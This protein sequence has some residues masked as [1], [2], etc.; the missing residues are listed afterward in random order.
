MSATKLTER[1]PEARFA[2]RV[3]DF[4]ARR[5]AVAYLG[6][7]YIAFLLFGRSADVPDLT[8]LTVF[9]GATIVAFGAGYSIQVAY[10]PHIVPV[11]PSE[12]VPLALIV[13]CATYFLALGASYL[14]L[15]G[16][17][18]PAAILQA[19]ANPGASYFD[20][21]HSE[22]APNSS[23][24]RA[25]T[26]TACLYPLLIPL[27][28]FHWNRLKWTV[29]ALIIAGITAYAAYYISIG[30]L[31][32]LGDLVVFWVV[33]YSAKRIA[34]RMQTT[35][36]R[37]KPLT[38]SQKASIAVVVSIF[39]G[40]MAFNQMTR[41][42]EAGQADMFPP[43]PVVAA[44]VGTDLATGLSASMF[45]PVHGY[46]GLGY[47]LETPFRW[48]YGLGGSPALGG[49]WQQ[50]TGGDSQAHNRYTART[51]SLSDWPDGMYW[52]TIYPWL[53]SDLTFPGTVLFMAVVGWFLSKFWRE[54][55]HQRRILS[56]SMLC[57][58]SLAIAFVPANNQIG[59]GRASLIAFVTTAAL[60]VA[61]RVRSAVKEARKSHR[62]K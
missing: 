58:I 38:K 3:V 13:T 14:Y 59:Q 46:L 37:A 34:D 28:V 1:P 43:N 39:L 61:D 60:S 2:A 22:Q 47:N 15:T 35:V 45:Y 21:L 52:S 53:A 49:Y 31:K 26:L 27:A 23:A 17:S 6:S 24:I 20:R 30:T 62:A 42:E 44:I 51:E 16:V 25:L 11:P 8:L 55:I 18:S 19:L 40:Y 29:R 7:T 50:Y 36:S 56:L 41:V 54:A 10:G 9:I 33:S 4:K 5:L 12:R 32:G 57:Q 48:T